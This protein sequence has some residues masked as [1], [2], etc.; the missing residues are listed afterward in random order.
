[1]NRP[2]DLANAA[3]KLPALLASQEPEKRAEAER[4]IK[5]ADVRHLATDLFERAAQ[6]A[7]YSGDGIPFW[8]LMLMVWGPLLEGVVERRIGIKFSVDLEN[9][10]YVLFSASMMFYLGRLFLRLLN[11]KPL[12]AVVSEWLKRDDVKPQQV[13]PFLLDC[14]QSGRN[15]PQNADAEQALTDW[16]L[17]HAINTPDELSPEK[18]SNLGRRA[19]KLFRVVRW[20]GKI[21]RV[22]PRG[23]FSDSQADF[24]VTFF[25][26][27]MLRPDIQTYER[28]PERELL[29]LAA[30]LQGTT[31]NHALVRDAARV[32][33]EPKGKAQTVTATFPIYSNTPQTPATVV[34]LQR[35][36]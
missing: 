20:Q 2:F 19:R 8:F 12:F 11:K 15:A 21:M 35:K 10:F 7:R 18:V 25:Q 16:L 9:F 4:L 32:L 14:W 27:L 22:V 1:M 6:H 33:L 34:T 26:H 31:E 23:V 36:P 13:L 5:E 17:S 24:L 28:K 30:Q 29:Q 3:E